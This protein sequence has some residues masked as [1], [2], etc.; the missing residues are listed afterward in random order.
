MTR[1]APLWLQG[2]VYPAAT[3]RKLIG[4]IWRTAGVEGMAVSLQS[5]TMNA[6]VAAGRAVVIDGSGVAAGAFLCVNDTPETVTLDTAPPA[7]QDRIDLIVARVRDANNDWIADKVNGTPSANPVA[8]VVPA[9]TTVIA[10]VRVVGGSAALVGATVTDRRARLEPASK[11]E[12][13][14]QMFGTEPPAWVTPRHYT[15]SGV[16]VADGDGWWRWPDPPAVFPWGAFTYGFSA[17]VINQYVNAALGVIGVSTDS[18]NP[19]GG[20][21]LGRISGRTMTVQ[22]NPFVG[23]FRFGYFI[24]GA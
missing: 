6:S 9:S 2:A 8:P 1:F 21:T 4:A 3:D 11:I 22:N 5:G 23:A 14:A 15:G 7:G 12:F 16:A 13:G 20:L 17:L 24:S 10:Q 18:N 19:P